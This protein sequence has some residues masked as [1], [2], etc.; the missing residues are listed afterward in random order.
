M[1]YLLIIYSLFLVSCQPELQKPNELEKLA[2]DTVKSMAQNKYAWPPREVI[3]TK[4]AKEFEEYCWV[5]PEATASCYT[6]DIVLAPGYEIDSNGEPIIHEMIH[7]LQ[8]VD[9][10]YI[11]YAHED[12]KYWKA[13]GGENSMQYKAQELFKQQVLESYTDSGI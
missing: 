7:W 5:P 6:G 11:D 1:K 9:E 10:N 3:H 12:P 8:Q 2:I 4:T 13:T